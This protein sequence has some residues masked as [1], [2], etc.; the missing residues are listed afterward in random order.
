M[1]SSKLQGGRAWPAVS[2]FASVRLLLISIGAGTF[3]GAR[4]YA[5]HV[6][7]GPVLCPLRAWTGLP[8]PGCG[9]TR[10]FCALSRGELSAALTFNACALPLALLLVASSCIAAAELMRG[11]A[12]EFY[13]PWFRSAA[14]GRSVVLSVIAYH[15]ARCSY[16]AFTGALAADFHASWA[17]RWLS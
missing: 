6:H 11:T 15:V 2:R 12:W 5:A 3:L 4:A 14:L 7:D 10:A 8:C 17:Y 13:R 16:W 9:L 1:T